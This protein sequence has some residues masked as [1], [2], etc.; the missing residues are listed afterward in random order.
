MFAIVK[1]RQDHFAFG[2][3]KN[4]TSRIMRYS[5]LHIGAIGCIADIQRIK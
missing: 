5:K 4:G 2:R 1:I 3:H